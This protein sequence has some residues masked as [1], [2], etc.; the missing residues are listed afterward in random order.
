MPAEV[1]SVHTA[2]IRGAEALPVSV[3]VSLSHGIPG[4]TLVGMPDTAVLEA[5]SRVRCALTGSGYDPPRLHITVN[6]APGELKKKGTGFDLPIAVAILAATHQIPAEGL[7]GMLFVGELALDGSVSA[8]RGMVA[9]AMLARQTGLTLVCGSGAD[10]PESL[11]SHVRVLSEISR[12]RQGTT[13]LALPPVRVQKAIPAQRLDFA[14]VIDQ[15]LAKR[16][17]VIAAAG[18]HGMLMVGPP[19]SGKSML[20]KR[21]PTIL[22][23]L[24]P[25]AELQSMLLYSVAGETY[26]GGP[27]HSRPFR[28]PHHSISLVGMVGGGSPVLP[29]EISLAHNGVLFLDELPE[30]SPGALQ[31]LRQ[32]MEDREVRIVRADGT[33]KFPCD[34][35]LIAAANPCPCGYLGDPVRQCRCTPA[36]IVKYQNRVGGPIVDRIDIVI[37]V[38]RPREDRIIGGQTGMSSAQMAQMVQGAREFAAWRREHRGEERATI[39]GAAVAAAC[40]DEGATSLL[41]GIASRKALSGR[42]IARIVRVARTIADIGERERVGRDDV[43]EACS[44]R[45][46]DNG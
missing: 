11:R 35:Q 9:H 31:A 5:R 29:G 21:L 34:F 43:A 17:M 45:L 13:E 23:P 24:G 20:A 41:E 32:P 22:A 40:F 36:Q 44:Y 16:A 30:F 6:L 15:E 25:D 18:D 37:N 8:V 26:S 46:Q 14:D 4:I 19:G 2:T 39:P 42:A 10:I 33:Y 3:E 7:D 28:A 27:G 12:L 1:Y 38:A